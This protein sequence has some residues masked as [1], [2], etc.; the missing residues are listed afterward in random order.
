MKHCFR[1]LTLMT[2]FASLGSAALFAQDESS[3]TGIQDTTPFAQNMNRAN[4]KY[5]GWYNLS[6]SPQGKVIDGV[7]YAYDH[8]FRETYPGLNANAGYPTAFAAAPAYPNPIRSQLH[9]ATGYALST[10]GYLPTFNAS[11]PRS[12][13]AAFNKV[14]NGNGSGGLN[15]FNADGTRNATTWGGS[16]FGPVPSGGS[17][18]VMSMSNRFNARGGTLGVFE[19]S[20]LDSLDTIALQIQIGSANGYDFYEPEV[21]GATGEVGISTTNPDGLAW[22]TAAG[23]QIGELTDFQSWAPTLH[24]TLIGGMTLELDAHTGAVIAKGSNG[25]IQMPTGPGGTLID[26]EIIINLYD[27]SWDLSAIEG[28]IESF[29]ITFDA[30]EHSQIYALRLDQGAGAIPEPSTYALLIGAGIAA[31]AMLRRRNRSA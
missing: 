7:D 19:A 17:L 21:S 22:G 10:P 3:P 18:Y 11:A 9:S 6:S 24:I 30:V 20:P 26:E 28:E 31:I 1:T 23:R 2:A 14:A 15:K 29:V 8:D 13:Q 27:F 12:S 25:T 5:D 4:V 16:G